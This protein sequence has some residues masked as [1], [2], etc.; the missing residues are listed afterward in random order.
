MCVSHKIGTIVYFMII[1]I[2]IFF[3]IVLDICSSL[4]GLTVHKSIINKCL[5]TAPALPYSKSV[6]KSQNR[7]CVCRSQNVCPYVCVSHKI[8]N[9]CVSHKILINQVLSRG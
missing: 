4:T 8:E 6:C 7:K 2:N 5:A 1:L 3:K 9:V